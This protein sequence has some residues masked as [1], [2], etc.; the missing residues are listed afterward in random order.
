VVCY[1]PSPLHSPFPSGRALTVPAHLAL[2]RKPRSARARCGRLLLL[3]PLVRVAPLPPSARPTAPACKRPMTAR[4]CPS[5]S[6]LPP[7]LSRL[8]SASLHRRVSAVNN[9]SC[10]PKMNQGRLMVATIDL[11]ASRIA[12]SGGG[13]SESA[14]IDDH[15]EASAWC[16]RAGGSGRCE[17]LRRPRA[18]GDGAGLTP[19]PEHARRTAGG[20][21]GRRAAAHVMPRPC[22]AQRKKTYVT[23]VCMIDSAVDNTTFAGSNHLLYLL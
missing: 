4:P 17:R 22:A 7:S 6:L 2:H 11:R 3:R 20:P 14:P 5:P 18:A 21:M 1:G 9:A 13:D 16:G 15:F 12:I 19:A 10:Q 23:D 8:S